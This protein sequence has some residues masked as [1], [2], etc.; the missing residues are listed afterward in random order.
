RR[1]VGNNPT[2]KVDPSGLQPGG[3]DDAQ[4]QRAA[5]A[6]FDV[7]VLESLV[8]SLSKWEAMKRGTSG[9]FLFP[10]K[11]DEYTTKVTLTSASF[12]EPLPTPITD[13]VLISQLRTLDLATSRTVDLTAGA[14]VHVVRAGQFHLTIT[15]M[16]ATGRVA[17]MLTRGIELDTFSREL[18]K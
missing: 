6:L 8:Q 9:A 15:D 5:R 13:A 2:N 1:F 4:Q 10:P 7:W 17:N 18:S 12:K 11:A 16:Q 3:E 14:V